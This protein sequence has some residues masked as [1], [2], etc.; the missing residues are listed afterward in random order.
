MCD[1]EIGHV[2]GWWIY[3]YCHNQRVQQ[4]HVEQQELVAWHSLGRPA[5][6]AK[7][8]TLGDEDTHGKPGWVVVQQ[9]E[10]MSTCLSLVSKC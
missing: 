4:S 3:E 5:G 1:T 10:G 7:L 6:T 8:H 2:Q 9:L